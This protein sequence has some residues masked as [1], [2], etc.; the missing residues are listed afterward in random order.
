LSWAEA[1]KPGVEV[2]PVEVQFDLN[3]EKFYHLFVKLLTASTPQ[4]ERAR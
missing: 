3:A 1:N 4:A 2:Q